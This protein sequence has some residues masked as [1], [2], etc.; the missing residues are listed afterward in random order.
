MQKN[1]HLQEEVERIQNFGFW[2]ILAGEELITST[3]YRR[4]TDHLQKK[5]LQRRREEEAE[6]RHRHA[7]I[8][9]GTKS[10]HGHRNSDPSAHEAKQRTL[11]VQQKKYN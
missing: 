1:I 7:S 5:H 9:A 10:E 11:S 2:T 8:V 3:F 4:R 6:R